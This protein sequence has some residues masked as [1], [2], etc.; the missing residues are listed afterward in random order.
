MW[1]AGPIS[2]TAVPARVVTGWKYGRGDSFGGSSG[3]VM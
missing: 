1:S 2:V 3:R